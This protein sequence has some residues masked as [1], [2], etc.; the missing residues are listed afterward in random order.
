MKNTRRFISAVM[1]LS[2]VS[3]LAPMSAFAA[4]DTKTGTTTATYD[5]QAKYT[6]TIPASATI[7][8]SAET[9][10]AQQ[11]KAENVLL[12]SGKKVV[13]TLT[14]A[15]NTETENADTF[16]AKNGDS[17]VKYTITAGSDTVALGGKVAEFESKAE[18]QTVDL[19]FVKKADSTPTYAGEHT[20]TLTFN[21]AVEE[22]VTTPT[23]ADTF[24]N[25]STTTIKVPTYSGAS[26]IVTFTNNS[27]TYDIK[28]MSFSSKFLDSVSV[29][30]NGDKLVIRI[31]STTYSDS[32]KIT[33]DKSDNSY[34]V[35]DSG[36]YE[37]KALS[38]LVIN[39]TEII[40]TISKK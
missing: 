1:A 31:Y 7:A 21:I 33:L 4:D 36:Y 32:F 9:A 2:M 34:S 6:V 10:T 30:P 23:L 18:Q 22:A 35:W 37:A 39:E 29:T 17:T 25:G 12:E 19:K 13:V 26:C 16:N 27:G 8:D 20:E 14:S 40:D 5:V 11:V 3:A 38:S 15:E 24:K 28:S